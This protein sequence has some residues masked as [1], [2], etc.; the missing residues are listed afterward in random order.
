MFCLPKKFICVTYLLVS[1][2]LLCLPV[3][4]LS[5]LCIPRPYP[6]PCLWMLYKL[7]LPSCFLSL[8]G[9][10]IHMYLN[11]FFPVNLSYINLIIRPAKE[12]RRLLS[13]E[14]NQ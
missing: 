9:V 5:E 7:Q 14:K 12:P 11:L 8:C 1:E 4:G 3:N 13:L 2:H 6:F 10:P